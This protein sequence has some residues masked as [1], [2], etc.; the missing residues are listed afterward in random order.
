MW[1]GDDDN[2]SKA[3]WDYL[4]AAQKHVFDVAKSTIDASREA[5]EAANSLMQVF[6]VFSP[7]EY[8]QKIREGAH[9][10]SLG[11]VDRSIEFWPYAEEHLRTVTRAAL[12]AAQTAE[13]AAAALD[14]TIK[15]FDW[16]KYLQ[17]IRE[18]AWWLWKRREG[19]SAW[20]P[21]Q[22]RKDWTEAEQQVRDEIS[23]RSA[24]PKPD[25]PV[26]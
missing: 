26:T 10:M 17:R 2:H 9:L 1:E 15:S 12:A 23:A 20:D 6:R 7:T 22:A 4:E 24:P 8:M 19:S 18:R 5:G 21:S 25:E 11:T 13:E 14:Q 3:W 16:P